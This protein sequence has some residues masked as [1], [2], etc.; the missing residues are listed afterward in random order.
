[1]TILF[2]KWK[3][4]MDRLYCMKVFVEVVTTG[5]FSE[6]ARKL[7]LSKASTSKYISALEEHLKVQLLHRTTRKISLTQEGSIF[8]EHSRRILEDVAEAEESLS[9]T[10]QAP[11]G[12]LRVNAPLT[13]SLLHLKNLLPDFLSRYPDLMLDLE[14]DDRRVDVVSEGY[15]VV[16]RIGNLSDSSLVARK[17]APCSL[18]AVASPQYLK[19]HGTPKKPEDLKNHSTI[20][21]SYSSNRTGWQ[22]LDKQ[23]NAQQVEIEGRLWLNNGEV[24]R[25]MAKEGFGIAVLPTF[26]VGASLQNGSL[27]RI[28]ENYTVPSINIYA[29]YPERRYLSGKVRVFIDY[30]LE[31]LGPEPYWD[32][33]A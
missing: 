3:Y 13:F 29:V 19:K 10:N 22:F 12:L 31:K 32:L 2:Q 14:M 6:A 26:I 30:L 9:D 21:Y 28:L 5:S 7:R 1:M 20:I 33:V 24:I 25:H 8:L 18:V 27:V 15:D 16:L 23:G 11:R 4:D 17:I